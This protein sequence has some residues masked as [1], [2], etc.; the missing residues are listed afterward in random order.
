MNKTKLTPQE[1][2]LIKG[3]IR[4]AFRQNP[5]MKSVLTKAR[6]ELPP[7]LK[8]DG[9]PGKK[10]QV[11]YR[12]AKCQQLVQSKHCQVD[13][14]ETVIPLHT[15]ELD[16]NFEDIAQRVFCEEENLQVLCSTPMKLLSNGEKS[17]H[18][19]KCRM[20]MFIRKQW[21]KFKELNPTVVLNEKIIE[22]NTLTYTKDY[23][24]YLIDT[25]KEKKAKALRKELKLAK[26]KK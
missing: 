18:A 1:R 7:A 9:T 19:K 8:K 2:Y 11:R 26:R 20:E 5:R 13:H 24:Q 12:C 3:A 16:M 25:E 23:D 15:S 4:R 6:V 22:E 17:C 14:I 10:P 21:D